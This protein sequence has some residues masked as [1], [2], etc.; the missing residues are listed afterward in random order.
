MKNTEHERKALNK[1]LL[2]NTFISELK[3]Q[4]KIKPLICICDIIAII[5]GNLLSD[6]LIELWLVTGIVK[7]AINVVVVFAML[8]II[9]SLISFIMK[10]KS[11]GLKD[12]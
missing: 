1:K 3:G 2:R 6:Y 10:F 5:I 9:N 8:I 7:I 12:R 4:R 11:K